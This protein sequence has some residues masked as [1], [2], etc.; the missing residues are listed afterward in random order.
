MTRGGRV[1]KGRGLMKG[2]GRCDRMSQM[3]EDESSDK[4]RGNLT[5]E[6]SDYIGV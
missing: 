2:E 1:P 5:R 4:E 6:G 3:M